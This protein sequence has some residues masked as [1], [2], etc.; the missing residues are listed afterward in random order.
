MRERR[1][2]C[3][4]KML[5]V[6]PVITD[7]ALTSPFHVPQGPDGDSAG[8]CRERSENAANRQETPK[9]EPDCMPCAEC[10]AMVT[11]LT[12]IWK[13]R[14]TVLSATLYI[15]YP[16]GVARR[17]PRIPQQPDPEWKKLD[18]LMRP[19]TRR[20]SGKYFEHLHLRLT[21]A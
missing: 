13:L 16:T 20:E 17:A 5:G 11:C 8:D 3:R 14:N 15:D 21:P 6:E 4:M 12:P 2:C 7:L 9:Q 19:L 18:S 10:T 1:D